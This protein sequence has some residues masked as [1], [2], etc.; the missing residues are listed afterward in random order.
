MGILSAVN[1]TSLHVTRSRRSVYQRPHRALGHDHGPPE[2][3][4]V[5]LL[6]GTEA[7]RR[8]RAEEAAALLAAADPTEL[9]A[10]LERLHV[11]VLLGQRLLELVGDASPMLEERIDT[12]ATWAREHGRIHELTTLSILQELGASWGPR[13]GAERKR[14]GPRALRRRRRA[15]PGRHRHSGRGGGSRCR[16]CDR[17]A[18]G[19]GASGHRV[20]RRSPARPARV[21]GAYDAASGGAAL[22]GALVRDPIRRRRAGPRGASGCA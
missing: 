19:V 6:A 14:S 9:L 16:G 17:R 2:Q 12:T 11:T 5:V 3:R 13:A 22:A 10:L 7:T 21:T 8:E 15:Q 4:L 18:D 1:T 20:T